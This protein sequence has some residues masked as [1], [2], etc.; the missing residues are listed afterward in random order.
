MGSGRRCLVTYQESPRRLKWKLTSTSADLASFHA[1]ARLPDVAEV[2]D[3]TRPCKQR[4]PVRSRYAPLES[5]RFTSVASQIGQ[6]LR[7]YTF[8]ATIAGEL[9]QPVCFE[10]MP[11]APIAEQPI[12]G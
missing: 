5:C 9:L 6:P 11:Q 10:V 4:S 2:P 7:T 12:P 8:N 3:T 1:R